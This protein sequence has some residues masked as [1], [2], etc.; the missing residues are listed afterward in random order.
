M[1]NRQNNT[2][3]VSGK[4]DKPHIKFGT[5]HKKDYICKNAFKNRLI[6]CREFILLT[7]LHLG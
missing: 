3:H 4:S 6:F 2:G 5:L 1:Y 7:N